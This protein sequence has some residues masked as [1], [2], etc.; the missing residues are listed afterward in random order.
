VA[1]NTAAISRF[2]TAA[3][4]SF[5]II[6]IARVQAGQIIYRRTAES[7]QHFP[8]SPHRESISKETANRAG[9]GAPAGICG[10]PAGAVFGDRCSALPVGAAPRREC[11]TS[12]NRTRGGDFRNPYELFLHP[13]QEVIEQV[14]RPGFMQLPGE[15]KK[16]LIVWHEYAWIHA[17]S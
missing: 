14:L 15:Y 13:L 1:A 5:E 8:A 11:R 4:R 9:G 2:V 17:L 7:I 16:L 10:R 3:T 12:R 6:V